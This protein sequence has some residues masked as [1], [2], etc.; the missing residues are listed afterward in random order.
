MYGVVDGVGPGNAM[1]RDHNQAAALFYMFYIFLVNFFIINL[2]LGTIVRNFNLVQKELDGS[3]FLTQGQKN[4]VKTQ[5]LM[6]RC[7]PK[8]KFIRPN[9]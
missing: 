8:I 6:I 2:Y 7:W 3:L 1:S 9:N 4:W 5:K